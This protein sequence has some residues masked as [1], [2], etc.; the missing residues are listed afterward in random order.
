MSCNPVSTD[1]QLQ[2][3][4]WSR[5]CQN[6][7]CNSPST[8]TWSNHKILVCTSLLTDIHSSCNELQP[9]STDKQ[10]QSYTSCRVCQNRSCNS[11]STDTGSNHTKVLLC[12]SLLTYIQSLYNELTLFPQINPSSH[13]HVVMSVKTGVATRHLQTPDQITQKYCFV[14]HT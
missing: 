1:K 9:V 14:P 4:T 6:R 2:S 3:Y 11:S 12:T 5:V 8:D 7:S 13:I 10:L